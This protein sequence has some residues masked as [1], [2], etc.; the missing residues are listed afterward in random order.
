MI[1]AGSGQTSHTNC[2]N[3]V[4]TH[5]RS[6]YLGRVPSEDPVPSE[7]EDGRASMAD[8]SHHQIFISFSTLDSAKAEAVCQKLESEGI[9]CW[10]SSRDVKPGEN[11]QAAIVQA[12]Q[13]ARLMV[14]IFSANANASDEISKELSLASAFKVNVIPL[15]TVDVRPQGAFLYELATRQ[16]IDAFK[17]WEPA[18]DNLVRTTRRILDR[19][20]GGVADASAPPAAAPFAPPVAASRIS[21]RDMEAAR[22]TLAQF[23]GPIAKLLVRKAAST[24]SSIDEFYKRLCADVP[25][26]ERNAFLTRLRNRLTSAASDK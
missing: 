26:E 3:L 25:S 9:R 13:C 11:Y 6:R 7:D 17:E 16:W 14:L 20:T 19:A 15:R 5:C 10:I 21:E 22:V 4:G 8:E 1:P 18:L 2:G 23:V 24:A 12:I